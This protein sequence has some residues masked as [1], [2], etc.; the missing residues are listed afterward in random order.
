MTCP[1]EHAT[2]FAGK[3]PQDKSQMQ[4]RRIVKMEVDYQ[5]HGGPGHV[6]CFE[7]ATVT[8]RALG[9]LPIV[10]IALR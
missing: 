1:E 5:K 3:N 10:E 9:N 4:F 8:R 6:Y 2:L 7:Q